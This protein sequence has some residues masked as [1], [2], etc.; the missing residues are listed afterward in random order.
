MG[1]TP[2]AERPDSDVAGVHRPCHRAG[3]VRPRRTRS[4]EP[5]SAASARC[6]P[7][8]CSRVRPRSRSST[9]S[10]RSTH[11]TCCA[12]AS[13]T[14]LAARSTSWRRPRAMPPD[15]SRAWHHS[16]AAEVDQDAFGRI[17]GNDAASVAD[18][19]LATPHHRARMVSDG[20]RMAGFAISGWGG[21]TGYVQR[22]A[23][24]HEHRRR[25][26]RAG[27]RRRLVGLDAR[28]SDHGGVRQHRP[29]Q[30]RRTGALRGARLRTT[31]RT[32]HHRRPRHFKMKRS[33]AGWKV[34]A[35]A[36]AVGAAVL[37]SVAATSRPGHKTQLQGRRQ[38]WRCEHRRSQSAP[39]R[40]PT[41]SS[42]SL[43]TYPRSSPRRR[44]PRRPP[45]RPPRPPPRPPRRRRP[46]PRFRERR[47]WLRPPPRRHH[48]P[49]HQPHHRRRRRPRRRLRSTPDRG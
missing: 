15:R 29:G 3:R 16:R 28:P 32:P 24:H 43:P 46:P 31:G 26:C 41:S 14:P 40:Q 5:V 12:C 13:T 45:P 10:H 30:H 17:W 48:Q 22:V 2:V 49:H 21:N 6:A 36:A 27:A 8:R 4:P 35:T 37:L 39:D 7:P 9:A 38:V 47:P 44:P 33:T 25:G 11:C 34:V 19:R 23:V 42:S 18:I 1:A 20:G